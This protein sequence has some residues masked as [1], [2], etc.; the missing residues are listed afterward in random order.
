MR[1]RRYHERGFSLVELLVCV[2]IVAMV[3]SVAAP[4][5]YGAMMRS[6][7][8]KAQ[9]DLTRIQAALELHYLE[10][11]YYP[12]KLNDLIL[13]GYLRPGSNF[14]SPVSGYWYFYAVDDNREDGLAQAY[15]LGAP[16]RDADREI[17]IHRGGSLP[18]GRRPD[19][20]ARAWLR[21]NITPG[22]RV[23]LKLDLYH[24]DDY[25]H[26]DEDLPASLSDYRF[27]CRSSSTSPCDLRTN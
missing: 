8:A 27:S 18:E 17:R 7:E 1:R 19:L 15:A 2:A 14:R 10:Q 16:P 22:G 6:R 9:A 23:W 4:R 12:I 13:R 21:W 24:E 3:V 5:V 25:Y 20:K 11:H 26:N